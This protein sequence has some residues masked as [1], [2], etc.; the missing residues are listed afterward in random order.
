[1]RLL[2]L[3]SDDAAQIT[4]DV[5]VDHESN[6][7]LDLPDDVPLSV[8]VETPAAVHSAAE[9]CAAGASE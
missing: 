8:Y 2:D 4:N 7:E 6:P 9:F 3:R 1:M 5:D